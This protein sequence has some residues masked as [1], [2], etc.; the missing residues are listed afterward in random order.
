MT[1]SISLSPDSPILT[2]STTLLGAGFSSDTE[3]SDLVLM[4]YYDETA[5]LWKAGELSIPLPLPPP[6][7]YMTQP[8]T[9]PVGFPVP[10]GLIIGF[11]A[12]KGTDY[13]LSVNDDDGVTTVYRWAS[14]LTTTP[15]ILEKVL[16][17]LVAVLSAVPGSEPIL[18][19]SDGMTMTAHDAAGEPQFSFPV[20]SLRFVH[21]RY[22]ATA[23]PPRW[24]AVFCRTIF[25]R[26]QK[27]DNGTLRTEVFEIP[28]SGLS[29][30]EP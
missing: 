26:D 23:T 7:L 4:V 20:G 6:V 29:S 10:K 18:L 17:P 27:D 19:S 9:M 28:V 24:M 15:V 30:L 22:D 13:Y 2:G 16:D 12:R 3:T 5:G 11:A 1:R 25:I 8:I 21:E 14:G